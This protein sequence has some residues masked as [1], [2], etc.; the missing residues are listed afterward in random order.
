MTVPFSYSVYH[1]RHE[2]DY[3]LWMVLSVS[4]VVLSTSKVA[5]KVLVLFY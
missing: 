1:K 2:G 5:F 4:L 3:A